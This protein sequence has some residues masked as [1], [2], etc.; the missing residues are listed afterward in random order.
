MTESSLESLRQMA[1]A[2]FS[3][4]A[5]GDPA[6]FRYEELAEDLTTTQHRLERIDLTPP[7]GVAVTVQRRQR[8]EGE[9]VRRALVDGELI[10][11]SAL[12]IFGSSAETW[13]IQAWVDELAAADGQNWR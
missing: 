3:A 2:V 4:T 12:T 5:T 10:T 6:R 13:K 1:R 8:P 11:S 9:L 7:I